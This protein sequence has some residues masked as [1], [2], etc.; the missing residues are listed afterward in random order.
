MWHAHVLQVEDSLPFPP[1]TFN[2]VTSF[3]LVDLSA[4]LSN[5]TINQAQFQTPSAVLLHYLIKMYNHFILCL[6]STF[7]F[8]FVL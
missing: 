8:H 3:E 2:V 6:F 7:N 1:D 5:L 4:A